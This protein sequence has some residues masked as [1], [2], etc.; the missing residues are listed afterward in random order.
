MKKI[1]VFIICVSLALGLFLGI[2]DFMLSKEELPVDNIVIDESYVDELKLPVIEIDTLNP[3]YTANRQVRDTLRLI[4]EPLIDLDEN[5]KLEPVL[6]TEWTEKDDLTWIIKLRENVRWHSDKSFGPE[7]VIFTI[8][9]IKAETTST[10]YP[11]VSNIADVTSIDENSIAITLSEKDGL[12]PY[13]LNFP[14]IPN[15]YYRDDLY[16]KTKFERPIGTGPYKYVDTTDDE[17]RITL[18]FNANWWKYFDAKL[19]KIYLYK[20]SSYGEAIK[21]FK[22]SEIDVISTSMYS[23]KKKFGVI[24][25]NSYSYENSIFE[26]MIPNTE[27]VVL[28]E[29]SVRRAILYALN[30]NNIISEVYESNASEK[31]IMI[32]EYSWLYDKN[33]LVEYSP[34]K[35]KQLLVNAGWT[36]NGGSW[37]KQINGKTYTLSFN[38]MVNASD[39]EKI[40]VANLIKENLADVGIKINISKVDKNTYSQNISS[41]NFDLAL[42]DIELQSEYDIMD[43]F[44]VHNYARYQKDTFNKVFDKMYIENISIRD[45]FYELQSLYKDEIPYIGLYF[46]NDTLLT[47]KAVKGEISPT[48]WNVY[49]NITTWRK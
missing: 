15:Y 31:D 29:N 34:E 18:D 4:Y 42:A 24:G 11:N 12:L 13:K 46:K 35:S 36:Q 39:E 22:S 32:H 23:W 3:I 26:T 5:N 27:K 44:T 16:N 2:R 41:G 45:V 48:W 40:K 21:A 43:L 20:Y 8:N 19:R 1:L 37:S 33:S 10:Y 7:D 6:A 38:L 28:S 17:M 9:A 49:H 14:I 47:N 25:I 30:R